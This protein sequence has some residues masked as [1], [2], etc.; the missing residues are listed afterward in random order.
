M[1]E[2][3]SSTDISTT[4][5]ST[6]I[7]TTP[8]S[9]TPGPNINIKNTIANQNKSLNENLKYLQNKSL[10]DKQV[11]F[12]HKLPRT[13]KLFNYLDAKIKVLAKLY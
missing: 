12:Y 11:I 4:P 9:T 2:S 10:A 7:S 13:L 5:M 6:D 3:S 8:M 1:S